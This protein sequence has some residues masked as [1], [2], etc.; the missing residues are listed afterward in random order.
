MSTS[1]VLGGGCP[2]GHIRQRG[3]PELGIGEGTHIENA[4]ID[5]N[6]HV[7][8]NVK[9]RNREGRST[10]DDGKVVIREGIVVVPRDGIIPDGYSI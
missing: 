1:R 6:A 3:I 2:V 10:F 9:I 8:R 7:G 4:I 5:K